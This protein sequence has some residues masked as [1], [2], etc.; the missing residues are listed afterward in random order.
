MRRVRQPELAA[1][2]G[3]DG[4]AARA[5]GLTR[6]I[7]AAISPAPPYDALARAQVRRMRGGDVA[8][9]V[10]V[11][12]D[13]TVRVA[14]P[15]RSDPRRDARRRASQ[16]ISRRRR[17][18]SRSALGC[19]EGWRGPVVDRARKADPN[20]DASAAAIAH[21]P[22][23]QNWPV[24]EHAVIGNIV[25]DFPLINKSFNLSLQRA[26]SVSAARARA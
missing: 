20:G 22:S 13:E 17:R 4:L 7:C 25:P 11:R 12:F 19:V 14:A 3:L 16:R 24:L 6:P 1:K 5:S 2:L 26:R 23:W 21:D 10:A 9:R 18:R 8:A 15:D